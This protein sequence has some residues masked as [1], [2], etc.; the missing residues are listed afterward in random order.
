MILVALSVAS[1]AEVAEKK[2]EKRGI[3]GTGTGY[4]YGAYGNNAY[5]SNAYGNNAY[6]GYNSQYGMQISK[7][8]SFSTKVKLISH[9][10]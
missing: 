2:T 6:G 4:G 8:K 3:F 7:K 5:G 9:A 1:A 10:C